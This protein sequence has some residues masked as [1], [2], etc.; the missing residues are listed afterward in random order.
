MGIKVGHWIHPF[1]RSVMIE[2]AQEYSTSES[3]IKPLT[4]LFNRNVKPLRNLMLIDYS[5]INSTTILQIYSVFILFALARG[6]YLHDSYF[7]L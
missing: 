4:D 6:K 7:I 1:Q 5:Y 2:N 3:E